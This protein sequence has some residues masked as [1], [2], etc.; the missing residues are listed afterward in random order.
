MLTG[1][2]D[3][4][5][6]RGV[7][8]D[9][10]EGPTRITAQ[11][12]NIRRLVTITTH[13]SSKLINVAEGETGRRVIRRAVRVLCHRFARTTWL[14]MYNIDRSSPE[15][16]NAFLDRVDQRIRRLPPPPEGITAGRK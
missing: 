7:A 13:G 3:R 2:L 8:W 10:R 1:W 12:T 15:Q 4:V 9:L 5:L 11:L 14:A 6:I 16:R